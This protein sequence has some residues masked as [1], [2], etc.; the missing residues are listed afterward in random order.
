[1]WR[2][3]FWVIG[4]LAL[5]AQFCQAWFCPPVR[6]AA[7]RF[8]KVRY[9]AERHVSSN[10][11]P[12]FCLNMSIDDKGDNINVNKNDDEDD[13]RQEDIEVG[14]FQGA[15]IAE[16][17]SWP[18]WEQF[19][20][21]AQEESEEA[22]GLAGRALEYNWKYGFCRHYVS[23]EGSDTIRRFKFI[24]D[25]LAFGM[26]NGQVVLIRLSTGEV[27]DRFKEHNCEVTSIDFDG[28]NLVSGA[29]DGK[30]VHYS[31]TYGMDAGLEGDTDAPTALEELLRTPENIAE[32]IDPSSNTVPAVTRTRNV[33]GAAQ[34]KFDNFHTR[35][36]T[37]VKLVHL[38]PTKGSAEKTLMVSTS[39]DKSLSCIDL[40]TGE[41]LYSDELDEA[42]ICLDAYSNNE[43]RNSYIAV[44]TIDGKV[45]VK[46]T[47][48]GKTLLS[49]IAD[50]RVRSIH[51]ASENVIVTGGNTGSV[52]RWDLDG[53]EGT[54]K[55][56]SSGGTSMKK[57]NENKSN[58]E[59]TKKQSQMISN[60][61]GSGSGSGSGIGV[62]GTIS[63]DGKKN[64]ANCASAFRN[65]GRFIDFY[66]Q[67]S[68]EGESAS[69]GSSHGQSRRDNKSPVSATS[70]AGIGR[71][72][73]L[74]QTSKSPTVEKAARAMRAP[75]SDNDTI[76]PESTS[77]NTSAPATTATTKVDAAAALGS[78][79]CERQRVYKGDG[80]DSPVVA[81]QADEDK[82]LACYEDG[83]IK[84][85]DVESMV[86]LFDLQGR[87]S[88]ISCCQ[89]DET[90]LIAD[91]THH[92]IVTHDFSDYRGEGRGSEA[93]SLEYTGA[94][95]QD[96]F[97]DEDEDEDEDDGRPSATS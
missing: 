38:P 18:T 1:M 71:R 96:P 56:S 89:F 3:I 95:R 17:S 40:A 63:A 85:W 43:T 53:D 72:L 74:G 88:L 29:A 73:G 20:Q 59:K 46:S 4:I 90:R 54:R 13:E 16:D 51:F 65:T 21:S 69:G 22:G 50:D 70:T 30:I 62:A 36:V 44:G 2:I 24:G 76:N 37:G 7:Q 78:V 28:I 61:G 41:I 48:N 87:T 47:K 49:F 33:M 92:I 97:E 58:G 82:I 94:P 23:F 32:D 60:S 42:P 11:R 84:A 80:Q 93:V 77:T 15:L 57:R 27:L 26:I 68:I 45:L 55:D 14:S 91:G 52:K 75:I 83:I 35:S 31:L 12:S 34:H 8:C 25:L 67:A 6:L 81:V 9:G 86:N 19:K 10:L 66:F 64:K 79:V 5:I 39:I